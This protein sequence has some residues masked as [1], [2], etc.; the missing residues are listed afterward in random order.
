MRVYAMLSNRRFSTRPADSENA[1]VNRITHVTK[2]DR[3]ALYYIRN[4]RD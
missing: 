4:I 2:T 1:L 3:A